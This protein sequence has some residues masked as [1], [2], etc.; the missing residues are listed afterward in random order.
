MCLIAGGKI[1]SI[2]HHWRNVTPLKR[3][4]CQDKLEAMQSMARCRAAS[5]KM[6]LP[7]KKDKTK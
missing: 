4:R 5:W 7:P 3:V 2:Q 1:G 6:K